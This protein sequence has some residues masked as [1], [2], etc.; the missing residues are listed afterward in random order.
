MQQEFGFCVTAKRSG[1]RWDRKSRDFKHFAGMVRMDRARQDWFMSTQRRDDHLRLAHCKDRVC[2][3]GMQFPSSVTRERPA[4]A[5]GRTAPPGTHPGDK[6]LSQGALAAA[7][8]S[9][10]SGH[11][12]QQLVRLLVRHG[13]A[14]SRQA[15]ERRQLRRF[16]SSDPHIP[17][18]AGSAPSHLTLPRVPAA[19]S[20]RKERY[21]GKRDLHFQH[22]A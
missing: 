21:D 7:T 2:S 6:D 4:M 5:A 12:K 18:F 3:S 14:P 22:A 20:C 16:S 1:D 19:F 13:S 11:R 8:N 15:A 9:L 10:P 17:F